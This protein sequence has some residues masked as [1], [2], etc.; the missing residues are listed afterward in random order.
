MGDSELTASELRK[1][2]QRGGTVKD[3]E[4]TAAQLRA[5]HGVHSNSRDFSTSQTEKDAVGL[6]SPIIAIALIAVIA[7]LFLAY[8]YLK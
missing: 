5:R 6:G 8:S 3:D 1:R 2:Y 4:L 7:I